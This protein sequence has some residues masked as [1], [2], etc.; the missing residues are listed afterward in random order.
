MHIGKADSVKFAGSSHQTDG[1]LNYIHTDVWGPT[2]NPSLRGKRYF[3][4][5]VDDF[6]RRSWVYSMHHKHKVLEVFKDWKKMIEN[7]TNRK[8][9]FLRSDNGGEYTSDAFKKFCQSEGIV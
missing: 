1:I 3:V 7:Q 9:K 2:Q 4:T 5:F 8:I 6:S